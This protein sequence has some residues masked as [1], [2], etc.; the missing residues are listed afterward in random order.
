MKIYKEL[1]CTIEYLKADVSIR[2]CSHANVVR[3][4]LKAISGDIANKL[5]GF[6]VKVIWGF[7]APKSNCFYVQNTEFWA[8]SA[9]CF[10]FKA[11][12]WLAREKERE[13]G[14]CHAPIVIRLGKQRAFLMCQN[15]PNLALD[16]WP[17]SLFALFIPFTVSV[18]CKSWLYFV[19]EYS[20]RIEKTSQSF[21]FL[22]HK[23]TKHVE[24]FD[25][26]C[27]VEAFL[28]K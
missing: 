8:P 14:R 6:L 9:V 16:A 3:F 28:H 15:N 4:T 18:Q 1:L 10:D 20:T 2:I 22:L 21:S 12:R 5:R 23:Q 11:Q 7:R 24:L 17:T 13:T 27:T 19:V 25:F 26:L